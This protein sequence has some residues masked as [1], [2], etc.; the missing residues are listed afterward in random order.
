LV[1]TG[2]AGSYKVVAN[3]ANK[4]K[5]VTKRAEFKT[6]FVKE[7]PSSPP[8]GPDA[9]P[10][11]ELPDESKTAEAEAKRESEE[12]RR[13]LEEKKE[14]AEKGNSSPSHHVTCL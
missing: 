9:T 6:W 14:R 8:G 12:K 5:V 1:S 2:E 4:L 11:D 7:A 13:K 3:L 10:N